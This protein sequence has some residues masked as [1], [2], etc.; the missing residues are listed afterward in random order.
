M[1]TFF[2][3]CC[4]VAILLSAAFFSSAP[5][6]AQTICSIGQKMMV[7]WNGGWYPATVRQA[8][9][10]SCF[11]HY[12]GYGN[13]WDEWVGPDRIQSPF[14]YSNGYGNSM[15]PGQVPAVFRVG[16]PVQVL[17][18]N[19]W[20][21]AHVIYVRGNQLYIHYDSYQNNWNE[22]IGPERYRRPY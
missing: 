20:W 18:G 8:R 11:V 15:V 22:W 2:S 16:D 21:P 10:S 1:R 12:D 4:G 7:S 13:K 14:G 9:G 6:R 3:F 5:A 17:W 19:Q